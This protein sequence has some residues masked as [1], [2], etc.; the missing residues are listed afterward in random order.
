MT[1]TMNIELLEKIIKSVGD[2]FGKLARDMNIGDGDVFI[3]KLREDLG[4][5]EICF[6]RDRYSLT[7]D[8]VN[9]I[10]FDE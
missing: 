9:D 5:V 4:S 6:I 10:F 3:K 2:D 1:I 8:Q 7:D